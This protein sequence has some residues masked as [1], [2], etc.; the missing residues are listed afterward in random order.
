[1]YANLRVTDSDGKTHAAHLVEVLEGKV[2]VHL[3]KNEDGRDAEP[4][5]TLTL[6]REYGCVSIEADF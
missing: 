5:G 2:I 6:R 1:M 3:D 4:D